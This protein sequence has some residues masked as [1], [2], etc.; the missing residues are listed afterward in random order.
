MLLSQSRGNAKLRKS[1]LAQ[2]RIMGLSLA[3]GSPQVC[4]HAT[5]GCRAVCVGEGG[6]ARVFPE[7]S[8][9][10]AMK[11]AFLRQKPDEFRDQLR[12]EIAQQLALADNVGEQ[13]VL[14]MN[15]FS[16]L[17]WSDIA[18][19]FPQVIFYDYTKIHSRWLK[20]RSGEW[21]TNYA[22]TFS[23]S[24]NP[25]HQEWCARILSGGGNVAMAFHH[26]GRGYCGH[27]AYRQELP[28]FWTIGGER[29]PVLDGDMSDLRFL[30]SGAD[31]WFSPKPGKGWIV[32]LR[33]KAAT[34]ADRQKAIETGF[35][36]EYRP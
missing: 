36:A 25:R 5:A 2:Y 30:D 35:S 27:G 28:G 9:S 12:R 18:R 33:L 17:D 16:D 21:P 4:P 20:I 6:M 1:E 24:E 31:A 19:Q 14:R 11:T 22:L 23:W 13:L 32:G 10:R 8:A 26:A 15:T 34:E 29:H 7:I 3:P